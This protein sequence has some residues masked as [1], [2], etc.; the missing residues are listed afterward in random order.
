MKGTTM[1]WS[2]SSWSFCLSVLV[3]WRLTHL[4]AKEDG[5]WD[6]VVHLRVRLGASI[7][8]H[9]MDCFYCLSLWVSLP[10][11]ILLG[12]LLNQGWP[13]PLNWVGVLMQWLA[14][15]GAACLMEKLTD[16]SPPAF[17]EIETV[18]GEEPCVVVK[19]EAY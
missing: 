17:A 2:N 5:P 8:G 15:S 14:L 12:K 4:L 13:G 19:N 9:L 18:K 16:K 3:V 10:L 11:A 1:N 6:T 7:L